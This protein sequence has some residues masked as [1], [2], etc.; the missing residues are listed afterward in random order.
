MLTYP[1]QD[2][3]IEVPIPAPTPRNRKNRNYYDPLIDTVIQANGDWAAF[4]F[5]VIGGLTGK[6]KSSLMHAAAHTR[7]LA[8][9]TTRQHGRLY[10]RLATPQQASLIVN[11]RPRERAG[12]TPASQGSAWT[13]CQSPSRPASSP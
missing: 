3:S 12:R 5:A 6:A 7:G 13:K 4:D 9:E 11:G 8:I 1:P 2:P 10:V